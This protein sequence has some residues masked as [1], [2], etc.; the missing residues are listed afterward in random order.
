[1]EEL[2]DFYIFNHI[3]SPSVC[4][5]VSLS[6]SQT[7]RQPKPACHTSTYPP[8]KNCPPVSRT[9]STLSLAATPAK[10]TDR[11]NKMATGLGLR[12]GG[13]ISCFK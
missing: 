10:M 2:S 11:E 3:L 9:C 13:M 7:A 1:M 8:P 6:L 4:V 5:Q 12:D